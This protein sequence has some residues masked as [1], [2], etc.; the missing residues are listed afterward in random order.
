MTVP[1]T[2]TNERMAMS[3]KSDNHRQ[4]GALVTQS[5]GTKLQF[6]ATKIQ[7]RSSCLSKV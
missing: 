2:P 4:V 3:K 7:L 1:A 5:A 6:C